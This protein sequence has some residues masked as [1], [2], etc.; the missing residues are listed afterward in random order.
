MI[1]T[2]GLWLDE[3]LNEAKYIADL[4]HF[5]TIEY[6]MRILKSNKLISSNANFNYISL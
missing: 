6:L 3:N 1:K 4:Y 2:F 5:T